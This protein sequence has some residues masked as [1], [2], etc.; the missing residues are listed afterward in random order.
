VK[1]YIQKKQFQDCG[2]VQSKLLTELYK[3]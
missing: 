3:V 2:V 1:A